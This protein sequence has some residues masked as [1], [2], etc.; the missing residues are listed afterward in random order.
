MSPSPAVQYTPDCMFGHP[1]AP[2]HFATANLAP[3]CPDYRDVFISEFG[4]AVQLTPRGI[5]QS[6]VTS[7]PQVGKGRR[8]LQVAHPIVGLDAIPVVHLM[9]DWLGFKERLGYQ[10]MNPCAST[11]M[12]AGQGNTNVAIGAT[13][14]RLE[15]STRAGSTSRCYA[16]H[17]PTTGY[18]VPAFV[19]NNRTPFFGGCVRL[20]AH[21]EPPFS[22]PCSRTASTVAAASIIPQGATR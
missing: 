4:L 17:A 15:D 14:C 22:V 10:A 7:V 12:A 19:P 18:L 20:G 3:C 13:K 9:T 8:P 16:P 2:R 21:R 6:H 11:S 1:V 5:Q